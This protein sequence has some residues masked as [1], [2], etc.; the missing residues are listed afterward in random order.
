MTP[1]GT[2][3]TYQLHIRV[4]RAAKI[5]IGK[6]GSFSFPAGRYIYTGSAKRNLEARIKRHLS[7]EKKLYWHID[8]LLAH[9]AVHV[10]RVQR[11]HQIEC[12][13]H[14]KT[15]GESVVPRFG[16]GDCRRG[17]ASHLKY[18]G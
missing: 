15:K 6:L 17:C 18:L 10:V 2:A 5:Q 13:L 14:Q 3:S 8:Y 9:P 12:Q 4:L 7:K 11:S 16:T 1:R